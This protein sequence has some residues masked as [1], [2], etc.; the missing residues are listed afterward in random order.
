MVP[1]ESRATRKQAH[2]RARIEYIFVLNI[3]GHDESSR[4]PT[5]GGH[6][7]RRGDLSQIKDRVYAHIAI[8]RCNTN[9][10]AE[11]TDRGAATPVSQE[12]YRAISEAVFGSSARLPL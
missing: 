5:G 9:L 1:G 7:I 11:C 12:R 10:G 4:R 2:G 8:L 3:P 6:D